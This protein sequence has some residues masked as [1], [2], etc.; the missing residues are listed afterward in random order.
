MRMCN[1]SAATFAV[2]IAT[3]PL[4]TFAAVNYNAQ[5]NAGSAFIFITGEIVAGDAA[6]FQGIISAMPEEKATVFLTSPGGLIVESMIIG[7]AIRQYHYST[8]AAPSVC[9]SACGLIWLA[10]TPRLVL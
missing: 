3:T 7:E 10:G 4:T 9:A 1:R 2:M 6:R 5:P 8:T